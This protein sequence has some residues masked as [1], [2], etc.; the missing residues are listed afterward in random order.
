MGDFRPRGRLLQKVESA[1]ICLDH[2]DKAVMN[3]RFYQ[4]DSSSYGS[5]GFSSLTR[6]HK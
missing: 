1:Y 5:A 2:L 3:A 4:F 6:R